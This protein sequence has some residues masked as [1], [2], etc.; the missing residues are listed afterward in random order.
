MKRLT[1]TMT[2]LLAAALL[3][4]GVPLSGQAK[5]YSSGGGR[6]YSS[7]S[8]H[9]SSSGSSR[10]HSS[11]SSSGGSTHSSSVSHSGGGSHGSS[12]S[13]NT[14]ASRSSSAGSGASKSFSSGGGK[15]YSSGSTAS[16]DSRHSYT[17]AKSYASGPG[18]TF[19]SGTGGGGAVPATQSAHDKSSAGFA[20]D[21]AAARARKEETSKQSYTRLKESQR[22]SANPVNSTLSSRSE[23]SS[24]RS[25]GSGP[26]PGASSYRV[27]P[28]PIPVFSRQSGYIPDA[29]TWASRPLRID[30]YFNPYSTRPV[31]IYRDPYSSLFW[32]WL[33][34]RSLDDRSQWVYHHRYDMDPARYQTLVTTDPQLEARVQQLEAQQ[35]ARDP[36]YVPA[37][38]DRDLMY[39]D[40]SLAHAYSNRPTLSGRVAF[41]VVCVPMALGVSG[42][43]IWL[44]WFKRWQTST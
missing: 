41:W 30:H 43:F 25:A 3:V 27:Q 39:S 40:R 10:S 29:G 42:F 4:V 28:P 21:T 1:Q 33:L 19:T 26:T 24:P 5:G 2:W 32:W 35:T 14:G 16:D 11:G 18:H 31:V 44:I 13:G 6:S 17:A 37:G 20:F 23:T 12:P 8:S 9:G 22:P 38:L 36:A 34:D 15:S 7:S